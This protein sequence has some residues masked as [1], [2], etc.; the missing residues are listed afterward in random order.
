MEGNIGVE[1]EHNETEEVLKLVQ[2]NP[3][4]VTQFLEGDGLNSTIGQLLD[5]N[6]KD[7]GWYQREIMAALKASE[8]PQ[9][10]VEGDPQLLEMV[11]KE[12]QIVTLFLAGDGLRSTIDGMLKAGNTNDPVLYKSEILAAIPAFIMS[13][14]RE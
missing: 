9:N 1:G 6:V 5:A 7:A 10:P 8:T 12:P 14:K 13:T 4:K 2:E 3:T 11:Q